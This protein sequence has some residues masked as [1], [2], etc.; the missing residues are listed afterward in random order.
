MLV[1]GNST[2]TIGAPYSTSETRP[3]LFKCKQFT[4]CNILFTYGMKITKI[5]YRFTLILK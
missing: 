5:T 1:D 4:S 3:L 2:K